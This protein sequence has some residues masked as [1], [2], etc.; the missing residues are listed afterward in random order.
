MDDAVREQALKA[1]KRDYPDLPMEWLKMTYDFCTFHPERAER[2]INGEEEVPPPKARGE[3]K[4][5]C[6]VYKDEEQMKYIEQN[7]GKMELISTE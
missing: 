1:M 3:V 6:T 4:Y 2:I 5:G 7:V